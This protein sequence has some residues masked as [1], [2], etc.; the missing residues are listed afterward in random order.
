MLE[1]TLRRKATMDTVER[2]KALEARLLHMWR[3]L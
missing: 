2:A 1:T 3:Y